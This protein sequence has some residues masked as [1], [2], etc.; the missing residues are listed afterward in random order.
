LS[1][2][3]V[4]YCQIIECQKICDFMVKEVCRPL[5]AKWYDQSTHVMTFLES[6]QSALSFVFYDILTSLVK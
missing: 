3:G 2:K 1:N 6:L 5:A 4:I